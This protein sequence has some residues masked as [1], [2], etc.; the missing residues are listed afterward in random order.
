MTN[1]LRMEETNR[2]YKNAKFCKM[3]SF[4]LFVLFFSFMS[5]FFCSIDEAL[6][7]GAASTNL[8]ESIMP[9]LFDYM[10]HP[11]VQHDKQ[12][13][14]RLIQY[15][16]KKIGEMHEL[17][18]EQEELLRMLATRQKKNKRLHDEIVE[19]KRQ[20]EELEDRLMNKGD[21]QNVPELPTVTTADAADARAV[22]G[23]IAHE[24]ATR[25]RPGDTNSASNKEAL[26]NIR[27]TIETQLKKYKR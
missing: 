25:L 14:K 10:K 22:D 5:I 8:H 6:L 23:W 11:G 16:T 12:R 17:Q 9:F 27:N 15:R 21:D 13:A 7:Q 18:D 4:V 3:S 20:I 24:L 1:A 19:T 2:S 26:K